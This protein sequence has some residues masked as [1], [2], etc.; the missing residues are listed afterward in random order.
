MES[1]VN[2]QF[3]ALA[4]RIPLVD[5]RVHIPTIKHAFELRVA[6][7]SGILASADSQGFTHATFHSGDTLNISGTPAAIPGT[8]QSCAAQQL[9]ADYNELVK[10]PLQ[11]YLLHS[12]CTSLE[13]SW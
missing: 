8:L 4:E 3:G 13:G 10:E 7:I 11:D 6:K 1:T 12:N 5:G 2:L 9:D